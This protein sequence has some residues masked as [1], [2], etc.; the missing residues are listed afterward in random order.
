MLLQ[1][2]Y[3][4]RDFFLSKVSILKFRVVFPSSVPNTGNGAFLT[5]SWSLLTSL[6]VE[7]CPVLFHVQDICH[8]RLL[9]QCSGNNL[10][11]GCFLI[12]ALLFNKGCIAGHLTAPHAEVDGS[13]HIKQELHNIVHM[14]MYFRIMH[15]WDLQEMGQLLWDKLRLH[16]RIIPS[17]N[18]A[19]CDRLFYYPVWIN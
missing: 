19:L 14:K 8:Q 10:G 1:Q 11:M 6:T 16:V 7:L 12:L 5:H 13:F 18:S 9:H 17:R 4:P 2:G 15:H 3:Q